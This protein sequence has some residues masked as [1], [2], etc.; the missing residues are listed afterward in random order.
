MSQGKITRRTF[1]AL[2]ASLTLVP[3]IIPTPIRR[4][5]WD[6]YTDAM[7]IDCLGSPGPFNIANR[8]GQPLSAEMIENVRQSGITAMNVTVDRGSSR[9]D[10][11]YNSVNGIAY[12]ER[13]IRAHPDVFMKI[14]SVDDLETAK[15]TNRFGIILGFQDSTMIA[16]DLDRVSLFYNLGVRIMQLTYN[17]RNVVGDGCLEPANAGLSKFGHRLVES[18][19]TAGMLV[20]ASHCSTNTTDDAI[21]ASSKPIGITHSGCK[22]V[23]DHPRSKSDQ[24]LRAMADKGGVVGIYLMPFLNAAGPPKAEHVLQHIEHAINVCG[25]DHVGI[26][27]DLSVTPIVHDAAYQSMLEEVGVLRRGMGIAAPREDQAPYVPDLNSPSRMELI[28]DLLIDNGHTPARVE[29]IIGG[30]WKRLFAEVW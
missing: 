28:A 19:N 29:K 17:L 18:L 7:V 25:E 1:N 13:E 30:N 3:S 9:Y 2:A 22:A 20:D 8:L 14:V 11:F 16:Q 24:T 26:G 6:D 23:F 21:A 10:P 15:E 4:P 27:S 5:S 12:F